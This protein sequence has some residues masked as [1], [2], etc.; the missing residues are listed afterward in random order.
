[1]RGVSKALHVNWPGPAPNSIVEFRSYNTRLVLGSLTWRSRPDPS[2]VGFWL[3][4]WEVCYGHRR[5]VCRYRC[6]RSDPE[7]PFGTLFGP[8]NFARHPRTV[9]WRMVLDVRRPEICAIQQ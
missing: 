4:G 9:E 8:R 5:A 3:T 2:C 6:W 7:A 1:M